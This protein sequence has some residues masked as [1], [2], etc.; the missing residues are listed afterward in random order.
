MRVAV[1]TE[2]FLPQVNGVTNSVLRVCEQMR[3]HG[4]QVLV[5]APGPGPEE[6]AGAAVVR[7]P[8]V[9]LPRY[10]GFRVG[11]PWPGLGRVLRDFRPDV[12]HLA[13]PAAL[14]ASAARVARRLDVPVVAVHQ[15]DLVGFAARYGLPGVGRAVW[16]GLRPV[17]AGAAAT[18]VPSRPVA[19][20]LRAR[21]VPRVRLWARG[22]DSAAFSPAHR[23]PALRARLAPGGEVVV[24]YVGRLAA[25]KEL[26]LLAGL[27]RMPG[28]RLVLVGDGPQRERLERALPG[29]VFAG[30]RGGAELGA[31]LASLDV[32]VH[33]GSSETFCQA[34]QEAL[35]SGVPVVAPAAGGPLDVVTA[36]RTGLF[37]TPGSAADLR[38]R[39]ARLVA[40]P[41][42]RAWMARAAR[43]SVR[44]RTWDALGDQL[45]GHY[46]D[47][48]AGRSAA[49]AAPE[50]V[51]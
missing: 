34:A 45:L 28:V 21:G 11:R 27:D 5:V 2:S 4:A 20:E 14:G 46:T 18:L 8:S 49:P 1:V 39:V 26:H 29:A 13:S 32:F 37:F 23:D 48:L 22:V 25:E 6:Y 44:G 36:G 43:A 7:S 17:Y 41:E 16:A 38:A 9:A 12:V 42:T 40:E 35:A 50:R 3:R 19:E 47:A 15:T 10:A 30:F 33:P 31:W 24:G 51:A